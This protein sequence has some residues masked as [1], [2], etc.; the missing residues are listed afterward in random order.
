VHPP[1]PLPR[2]TGADPSPL[3]SLVLP[4]PAPRLFERRLI[5]RDYARIGES[6]KPVRCKTGAGIALKMSGL[7]QFIDQGTTFAPARVYA[8]ADC[9]CPHLH[10]GGGFSQ[11][12]LSHVPQHPKGFV[13][14]V[15]TPI[16]QRYCPFTRR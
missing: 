7:Q 12:L 1:E 10:V 11:D 8:Y 6:V 13:A 9:C 2:R 3:L 16:T 15:Y 4:H 5:G 14:Y